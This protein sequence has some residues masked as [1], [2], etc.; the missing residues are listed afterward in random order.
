VRID[1]QA[2]AT[3][4]YAPARTW[5]WTAPTSLGQGRHTIKL[6]GVDTSQHSADA[7]IHVT[8]GDPCEAP[9]DCPSD[10][11]TCVDGRCVPGQNAVGGL[12]TTCTSNP[13]CHSG[14]CASD[15]EGNHHCVEACDLG[16]DGCP[17]G[18][19]CLDASGNGVCW[20]GG[21]DSGGC[22]TSSDPKAALLLALALAMVVLVRRRR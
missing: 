16:G 17:S 19:S 22:N 9:S 5:E 12:G 4:Y 21:D 15:T 18:F 7:T 3:L 6:T 1:G 13:D 14:Q 10:L 8:I 2:L 11:D 20:P